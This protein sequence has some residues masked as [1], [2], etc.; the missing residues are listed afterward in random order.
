MLSPQRLARAA[1]ALRVAQRRCAEIVFSEVTS[2]LRRE[3]CVAFAFACD[4]LVDWSPET[5]VAVRMLSIVK[6]G[7]SIDHG[8]LIWD[9]ERTHVTQAAVES[10]LRAV[11]A[12]VSRLKELRQPF[13]FLA[14]V[15]GQ[16]SIEPKTHLC[17][18]SLMSSRMKSVHFVDES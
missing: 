18:S 10:G 3:P 6:H 14:H 7:S 11:A 1:Q 16:T 15:E 8:H 13:E 5:D 4:D 2:R 17:L 12:C 9:L